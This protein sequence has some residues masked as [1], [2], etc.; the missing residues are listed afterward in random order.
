MKLIIFNQDLRISDNPALFNCFE[1]SNQDQEPILAIYIFDQESKRAIGGASMWFLYHALTSLAQDLKN[2][3]LDLLTFAGNSCNITKEIIQHLEISEIFLNQS[4]EQYN[5]KIAQEIS[6]IA[7]QNNIRFHGYNGGLLFKPEKIKNG[8]GDYFKV[9]TPFWKHC[10]KN[11]KEIKPSLP[12]P[13]K[14]PHKINN[15]NIAKS[16]KGFKSITELNLLPQ[17]KWD[18]NFKWEFDRHKIIA[19]FEDFLRK[20]I[21][22][23]KTARDFPSLESTSKLSPYFHFGIISVREI[24]NMVRNHQFQNQQTN[25]NDGI[26]HFLSEIGWREFSYHLLYHVPD[27]E[28]NNFRNEFDK[29]PWSNNSKLLKIWQKGQTGYPIVDAGMRE[30]WKT[31]WMH[32][33]VRMITASFLIKHLLIDWR[34]GEKW[35]WDCLVDADHAANAASWQWVAGSGADGAPFF[36]I[37]NPMLQGHR[38]DPEGTYVKKWL[39]ELKNLPKQFIHQPWEADMITLS[40]AGVELGKNYPHPIVNHQN[41]RDMAMM[42][43]KAMR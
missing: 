39:P 30:L 43:Y 27:L 11:E 13:A 36:R 8:N 20:K 5:I 22:N 6:Q 10:L 25:E 29:F 40:E 32:N 24:F 7:K 38:F 42:A 18:Q 35:F 4:Y 2:L 23:Y 34:A 19:N 9:F 15:L 28:R 16:I 3:N 17:I 12:A 26:N 1:K 37:F 21:I 41:S 14:S 31:G 33:R